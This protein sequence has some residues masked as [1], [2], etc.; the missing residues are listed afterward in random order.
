VSSPATHSG[1]GRGAWTTRGLSRWELASEL[2]ITVSVQLRAAGIPQL[3]VVLR[4]FPQVR[5][6][7][8][9]MARP[10]DRRRAAVTLRRRACSRWP[11]TPISFSS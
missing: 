2:G 11:A 9:H 8:D 3:E 4:R 1:E 6:L 5:I 7:L 10:G